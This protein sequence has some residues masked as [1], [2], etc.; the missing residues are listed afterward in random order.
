[1]R[2]CT[3]L[4]RLAMTLLIM[5]SFLGESACAESEGQMKFKRVETEITA[6]DQSSTATPTTI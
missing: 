2:R 3:S 6:D 1:M 4:T 5:L